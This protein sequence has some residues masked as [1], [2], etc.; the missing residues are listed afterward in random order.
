LGKETCRVTEIRFIL[1]VPDR[2]GGAVVCFQFELGSASL[3]LFCGST[4]SPA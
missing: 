3:I 4:A 2:K 1:A